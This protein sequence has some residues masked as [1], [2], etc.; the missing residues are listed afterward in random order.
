M[1]ERNFARLCV[2]SPSFWPG[3]EP[4]VI[5]PHVANSQPYAVIE[6]VSPP[7]ENLP[8]RSPSP[9]MDATGLR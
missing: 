9:A 1:I 7:G 2:W 4:M 8:P 5:G 3:G 6:D